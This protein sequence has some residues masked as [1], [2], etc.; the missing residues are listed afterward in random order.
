M[1]TNA[2][3]D[4]TDHDRISAAFKA[5]R[6]LGIIARMHF[7]CCGSCAAYELGEKYPGKGLIYYSRQ[8]EDSFAPPFSGW[9]RRRKP[10]PDGQLY[11]SLWI[12]WTL[13]P[14]QLTAVC[15]AFEAEGLTVVKP[16]DEATCI[17]VVSTVSLRKE[18]ERIE[19]ARDASAVGAAL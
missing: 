13:T 18:A 17:E 5:A 12:S 16:K 1:N 3:A 10:T 4:R 7:S 9:S 2:A 14:E 6:K 19:K 8:G 15:A 11:H